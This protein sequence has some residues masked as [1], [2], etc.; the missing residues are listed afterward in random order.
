MSYWV[1]GKHRYDLP[2]PT[3]DVSQGNDKF[4][5]VFGSDDGN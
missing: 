4:N 5:D 3:L 2:Y 1:K